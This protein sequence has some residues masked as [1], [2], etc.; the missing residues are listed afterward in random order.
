MAH[1]IDGWS[2]FSDTGSEGALGDV[3]E[4]GTGAESERAGAQAGAGGHDRPAAAGASEAVTAE[5]STRGGEAGTV[6]GKEKS[7]AG[8]EGDVKEA[9]E[10]KQK[11]GKDKDKEGKRA[12]IDVQWKQYRRDVEWQCRWLEL[13]MKEINGHIGRYERMLRGF[14]RLKRAREEVSPPEAENDAAENGDERPAAEAEA[15]GAGGETDKTDE[16][17]GTEGAAAAS[18]VVEPVSEQHEQKQK[19]RRKRDTGKPPEIVIKHPFF[20]PSDTVLES[21]LAVDSQKAGKKVNGKKSL[22]DNSG[23]RGPAGV[24]NGDTGTKG[25]NKASTRENGSDSDLSTAALYEQIEVLQQRVTKLHQRLGQPAPPMTTAAGRL[26]TNGGKLSTLKIPQANLRE[27][28]AA[29]NQQQQQHKGAGGRTPVGEAQPK[30][31]ETK[32]DFDINNVVGATTTGAKFVERAQHV[33]ITTPCVRPAAT[34]NMQPIPLGT[35]AGKG[36]SKATGAAAAAEEDDTSSEDT[37]DDAYMMRH[38]KFE[39]MERRARTAP[40][41]D[42]KRQGGA[43]SGGGIS[44]IPVRGGGENAVAAGGGENSGKKGR[45]GG[46]GGGGVSPPGAAAAVAAAP[47][48]PVAEAPLA[49]PQ[50]MAVDGAGAEVAPPRADVQMSEKVLAG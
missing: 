22:G 8:A 15:V 33:D 16:G 11:E 41:K 20:A 17:E 49:E 1:G 5:A 31:K 42:K 32:D 24:K 45:K 7:T 29:A 37:S 43:Q 12:A 13:R 23:K 38:A 47:V 46:G 48:A 30:R 3:E 21:G 26:R 4:P 34:F 27:R 9:K 50:P 18:G 40:A 6:A 36:S 39:L 35:S 44:G 19:K 28:L 14:E 2:S 10:G 25:H